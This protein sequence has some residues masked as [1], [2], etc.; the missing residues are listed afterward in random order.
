[1]EARSKNDRFFERKCTKK[2]EATWKLLLP[3][4]FNVIVA[5]RSTIQKKRP[6]LR[7]AFLEVELQHMTAKEFLAEVD[8][9]GMG[10]EFGAGRSP[11]PVANPAALA[12]MWSVILA[13]LDYMRKASED[14]WMV[15]D[16]DRNRWAPLP[17]SEVDDVL[18]SLG[19]DDF[20]ERKQIVQDF[21][22]RDS[23]TYRLDKDPRF[24]EKPGRDEPEPKKKAPP[25]QMDLEL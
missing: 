4:H 16:D 1:M 9:Q 25:P 18:K 21:R 8:R 7:G 12:E 14:V 11:R 2:R 13:R 20:L 6:P 24:K 22:D 15:W 17:E 5:S 3:L 23:K 19:F 10:A